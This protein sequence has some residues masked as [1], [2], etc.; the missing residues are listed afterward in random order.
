MK[1]YLHYGLLIFFIG[2]LWSCQTT[3]TSPPIKIAISKAVPDTDYLNYFLWLKSA[4]SNI[5]FYD[6]Y[7]LTLNYYLTSSAPDI[8]SNN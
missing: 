7:H 1:K 5:I 2:Y 8:T 6:L 3:A 4:D